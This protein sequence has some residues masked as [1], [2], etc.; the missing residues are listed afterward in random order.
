M[1]NVIDAIEAPDKHKFTRGSGQSSV[2]IGHLWSSYYAIEWTDTGKQRLMVCS[3]GCV[4]LFTRISIAIVITEFALSQ[5]HRSEDKTILK[6][7][8]NL[9]DN[10]TSSL[11]SA[12]L[13]YA[14]GDHLSHRGAEYVVRALSDKFD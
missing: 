2:P 4:N 8:H 3:L 11:K 13:F 1:I 9:T 7:R 12:V 5:C 10:A 6:R 14:D